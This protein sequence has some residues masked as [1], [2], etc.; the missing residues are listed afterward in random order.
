MQGQLA[1]GDFVRLAYRLG[2][3]AATGSLVLEERARHELYLRRGYLTAARVEGLDAPLGRILVAAGAVDEAAVAKRLAGAKALTGRALGVSETVLDA[4]LR[5]QA[6]LRLA[7]LAELASSWSF[8]PNAPAPPAGRGGR[9]FALTAWARRHIEA[10]FDP[11]R[12]R[13]ALVGGRLVLAKDLAPDAAECDDVDRRILAALAAP[14]RL[15]E[16]AGVPETR[17][18]AFLDFLRAVGALHGDA[19]EDLKAAYHEAAR[20]LHPDMHPDAGAAERRALEAE[21]ARVTSAYRARQRI[22]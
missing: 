11:G 5:R 16:I 17:L 14:R 2:R 20:R 21:F 8:D 10:G 6:E 9:P 4:A 18:L 22:C 7:H 12:A 15:H 1:R 13:A 3:E 19:P